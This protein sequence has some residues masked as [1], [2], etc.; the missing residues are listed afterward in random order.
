[1]LLNRFVCT[2]CIL[3]L[4]L[5]P[6]ALV[7]QVANDNAGWDMWMARVYSL[8]AKNE[9][10]ASLQR[11]Q[12]VSSP[13][14]ADWSPTGP[15]GEYNFCVF[16]NSVPQLGKEYHASSTNIYMQYR[17]FVDGLA[18][19]PE[20]PTKK[21]NLLRARAE[22]ERQRDL[23]ASKTTDAWKAWAIFNRD[24]RRQLE[25]SEWKTYRMWLSDFKWGSV[26]GQQETAMS[27]AGGEVSRWEADVYKGFQT[28]HEARDKARSTAYIK[29][30]QNEQGTLYACPPIRIVTVGRYLHGSR[31]ADCMGLS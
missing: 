12:V 13:Q 9:S 11:I 23:L 22:Y 7:A 14:R 4:A 30:I 24:Q 8:L 19:P 27:G 20:D 28:V 26:L 6:T 2:L 1:M 5:A 17:E 16:A 3:L 21:P 25:K 31:S 18:I 15:S 29:T 10:G